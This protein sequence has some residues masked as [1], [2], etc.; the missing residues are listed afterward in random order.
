MSIVERL[1]RFK[2]FTISPKVNTIASK[3]TSFKLNI[4]IRSNSWILNVTCPNHLVIEFTNALLPLLMDALVRIHI[5]SCLPIMLSLLW[6]LHQVS[7]IWFKVIGKVMPWNALEINWKDHRSY[8]HTIAL[9]NGLFKSALSLKYIAWIH[10]Y[11]QV[12][13]SLK[14]ILTLNHSNILDWS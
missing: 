5:L 8:L 4:C 14:L 9:P 13:Y 2:R 10:A 3:W 7:K 6:G 11:M 12:T 1:F